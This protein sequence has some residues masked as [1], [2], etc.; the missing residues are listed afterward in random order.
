[1]FILASL[2]FVIQFLS[3]IPLPY[4]VVAIIRPD[5]LMGIYPEESPL[6][7]LSYDV[8]QS[9][10]TLLK[11]LAYISLLLITLTIVKTSKRIR[12]LLLIICLAG[13]IQAIYG[14]FEVLLNIP[15]SM[16]FKY[17]ITHIA[18]GSFVYKNHFANY[19]VLTLSAALGY[20][21]ACR[22]PQRKLVRRLD[23]LRYCLDFLLSKKAL[24]RISIIIMVIALIMSRSRMGNTAFFAAMTITAMLG[25]ILFKTKTKSFTALFI[26]LLVIDLL[27]VSSVFGLSEVKQRIEQTNFEKETRDEVIQDTLPL[28][29]SFKL[30]GSGG[31]TFYTLYPHV[32]SEKVQHFYDHAHNEYLQFTLEFGWA[33]TFTLLIAG[34]ICFA[35]AVISLRTRE[36]PAYLGAAFASVMAF[37]GMGMHSTVDF[38]LQAPANAATFVIMLGMGLLSRKQK[39]SK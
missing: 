30:L 25:L 24:V 32:Q 31:G 19:L 7:A 12:L 35:T 22:N 38:P 20:L 34:M 3:I 18:T 28:L 8:A 4:E 37:I 15:K 16:I 29:S 5:R 11:T 26:S 21:I 2:F 33:A 39:N 17:K 9:K 1:M 10:V 27:L 13:T 6:L 36:R 23:I 14:A